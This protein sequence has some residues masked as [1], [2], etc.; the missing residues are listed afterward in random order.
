MTGLG[1]GRITPVG[2]ALSVAQMANSVAG[3]LEVGPRPHAV[4]LG[5]TGLLVLLAPVR[6]AVLVVVLPPAQYGILSIFN[7]LTSLLPIVLILG[8]SLEVQRL[9][10]LG[11][12]AILGPLR[13][14][15]F[16]VVAVMTVPAAG[17]SVLIAATLQTSEPAPVLGLLATA[18]AVPVAWCIVQSQTLLGLGRRSAA[19]LTLFT[20]NAL[21]TVSVLPFLLLPELASVSAVL[22]V[23]AVAAV[24]GVAVG[25]GLLRVGSGTGPGPQAAALTSDAPAMRL[26]P[27]RGLATLPALVGT[28][29]L[30]LIARWGLGVSGGPEAV[31]TFS[32]AWTLA[33]LGFLAAAT[34]PNLASTAIILGRQSPRAVF[35]L[36]VPVLCGLTLMGG[37][38]LAAYLVAVAPDYHF[39]AEAA[40]A[41]LV[42][43]IA[44][45][46]I[47]TWLPKS[48]ALRA[49]SRVS[50]AFLAAGVGLTVFMLVVGPTTAEA[51]AVAL[52][53]CF[54]AIAV[55]QI[56]LMPHPVA[57]PTSSGS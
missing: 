45:L 10:A 5:T 25:A 34:V 51:A 48:A 33:D 12:V 11:G 29:Y 31:A 3:W 53:A 1:R 38:A 9:T 27:R 50:S 49:Q 41:M 42:A 17:A 37:A 6:F 15:L 35:L 7:T 47:V 32:L 36:A 18:V 44:R 39:S 4:A 8:L 19:V 23:W 40:A 24:V 21:L 46:A 14:S 2:R 16:A 26:E 22:A 56:G 52:T 13:R 57:S 55:V 43:A 30:V 54:C 20:Y 28:W